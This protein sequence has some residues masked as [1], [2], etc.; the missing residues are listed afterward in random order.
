MNVEIDRDTRLRSVAPTDAEA[1][2]LV[3]DG[4]R[5]YLRRWLP[6]VD[7]TGSAADTA[8]FIALSRENEA[9]GTGLAALVECGDEIGGVVGIEAID[10][11]RRRGE[12]GYWLREDLQGAG[13]MTRAAGA[14]CRYAFEGL[15][16]HRL[17]IRV[18]LDNRPSRAVAERL[19]FSH[20]GILR[21]AER[22]G[23]GFCDMALYARLRGDPPPPDP[24]SRDPRAR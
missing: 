4:H 15:A 23:A 18:A 14:M 3:V 22:R 21:G 12:I 7:R 2:F 13:L 5:E 24:G 19:G 9:A 10:R 8:A 1:L 11:H 16:L 17:E 6:W 20:E